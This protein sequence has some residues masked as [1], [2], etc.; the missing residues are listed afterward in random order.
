ML[1]LSLDQLVGH[2]LLPDPL[3]RLGIRRLLRQR[4]ADEIRPTD[5]EQQAAL[6]RFEAAMRAAPIAVQTAAAN[7]QHYEVP[8][9]FY[10]H[11]LG[12]RL[13]Y[14]SGL[15]E[16]G[17]TTLAA[18]EEAMLALTAERAGLADGQDILELGCGWGSLSLW[19][20]ERY[21]R[22]R[23]V[24]VSNS[25]TQKA[26]I[27]SRIARLGL[28]N[29]RVL[30][31]DMNTLDQPA[32]AFDR[33]VSVEMFEHMRNWAR[34]LERISGWLRPEGRLFIH[35]FTH[36]IA[37]YAFEPRDETDWMSRHFFSGGIMPSEALLARFDEHL[38]IEDQWRVSGRHYAQTAEAWL[39]NLD[40]NRDAVWPV[41]AQTYGDHDARRWQA[42]WRIFFM[43]CAQLWGFRQGNEWQVSHYR[44]RQA[45]APG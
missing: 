21:P 22:A 37:A 7:T 25:R 26:Y 40:R 23:I 29:L 38:V 31:Q 32:G 33:V 42:Y 15:W 43:A 18:A 41:L 11:C 9:A 14:S 17:T 27:D 12:P 6:D 8:T 24:A 20:A 39:Q 13:K 19:M 1:A 30:T 2:G 3:L 16:H 28:T 5:A 45:A 4:L 10:Q 36:R 34:L 44:L 35:I